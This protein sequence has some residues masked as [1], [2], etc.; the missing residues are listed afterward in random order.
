MGVRCKGV[1][2]RRGLREALA[3]VGRISGIRVLI[4][5]S[6]NGGAATR[7]C[8]VGYGH[9][10]VGWTGEAFAPYI[11]SWCCFWR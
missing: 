11:L 10:A 2:G 3:L 7:F 9:Y 5:S 6:C 1:H 8:S 4:S